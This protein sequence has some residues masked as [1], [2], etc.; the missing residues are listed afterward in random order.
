MS[1]HN[2]NNFNPQK[3]NKNKSKH[4]QP[5]KNSSLGVAFMS[6][7]NCS[8][9]LIKK[10]ERKKRRHDPFFPQGRSLQCNDHKTIFTFHSYLILNSV[11]HTKESK[12]ESLKKNCVTALPHIVVISCMHI[13]SCL[14][15]S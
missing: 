11:S 2:N 6:Q 4:Q 14:F 5:K 8:I 3:L 10:R 15:L 9:N 1:Y 12:K 7:I 13:Q